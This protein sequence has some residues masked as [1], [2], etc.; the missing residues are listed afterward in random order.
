MQVAGSDD[1]HLFV[2]VS[3]L[4]TPVRFARS[5]AREPLP[6]TVVESGAAFYAELGRRI[7]V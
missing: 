6:V 1:D 5:F 2:L 4:V 7:G 3:Q